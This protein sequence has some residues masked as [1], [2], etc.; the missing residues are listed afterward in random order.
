V[1][2]IDALSWPVAWARPPSPNTTPAPITSQSQSFFL[3][4]CATS[5]TPL[6]MSAV[7]RAVIAMRKLKHASAA[8]YIAFKRLDLLHSRR[9]CQ[10]PG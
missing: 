7:L 1:R 8:M 5:A 2:K 3:T 10:A 6:A 9:D 4:P